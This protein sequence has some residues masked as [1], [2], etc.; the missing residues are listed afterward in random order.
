MRVAL[1]GGLLA[2]ACAAALASTAR[3][4]EVILKTGG[5]IRGRIVSESE[6]EVVIETGAGPVKVERARIREV[7]R[8]PRQ[9]PARTP[10]AEEDAPAPAPPAA[11]PTRTLLVF[12]FDGA[13]AALVADAG[14]RAGRVLGVAVEVLPGRPKPDERD[15]V[16]RRA[17]V[18]QLLARQ[19]E[20]DPGGP[21]EE[22][23]RRVRAALRDNP[24]PA[25]REAEAVLDGPIPPCLAVERLR[26]QVL[27][28]AQARLADASVIGAIG[29]VGRDMTQK[30]LNFVFGHAA[31]NARVGVASYWR[32][33]WREG[34]RDKVAHR[35]AVQL[36]S[37]TGVLLGLGRCEDPTCVRAFPNNLEEHDRKRAFCAACRPRVEAALRR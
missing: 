22:L 7:T 24:K 19:L 21:S 28:L 30:G 13:D 1:R 23:E 2:V 17:Q 26:E 11:T 33:G 18:L 34:P 29:V 15:M 9:P 5:S 8:S 14:A 12:A 32:F 31:P 37:T 20:L 35:L 36:L 27:A 3:A 25:A 6:Q 4:D 16:D 10:A